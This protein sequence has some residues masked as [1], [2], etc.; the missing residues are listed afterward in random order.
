MT[1]LRFN[2]V[3]KLYRQRHE[4][5]HDTDLWALSDVDFECREGE[6]LGLVGRN[7]CGKSTILKL[8]ARVTSPTSGSIFC[9]PEVAPMLELGAGFH[10]DLS[11]RDNIKLNGSLLGM[12]RHLSLGLIEEIVAFAEVEQHVDTPV[13]HYSSGMLARLGFAVAVHSPARLLLIDEVLSVGDKL[14][15]QKCLAR[16]KYLRDRG[17]TIVLVSHEDWWI[18][19]FCTRALLLDSGRIVADTKPEDALRAYDLRLSSEPKKPVEGFAI[20]RI[21]VLD[22]EDNPETCIQ[23]STLRVRIHYQTPPSPELESEPKWRLVVYVRRED[24][25]RPAM[26]VAPV[27]PDKPTGVAILDLANLHLVVASYVIEASIEDAATVDPVITELSESFFV[28]GPFDPRRGFE[29]V[30]K[31][32]HEWRFT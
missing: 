10:P 29:G 5:T 13:K 23:T 11:G 4:H 24:G 14:F 1:T 30:V 18:R 26:A 22:Q 3:S 15:Q 7:G 9:V 12:G 17:T 16:M 27:P 2:H 20:A 28:P 21:E 6:V 31:P 19:S 32:H 8:A 25:V